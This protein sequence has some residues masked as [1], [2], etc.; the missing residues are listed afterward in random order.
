MNAFTAGEYG[1]GFETLGSH[2]VAQAKSRF[3]QC[4]P[5]NAFA[6][7]EVGHQPVCAFDVI[8]PSE[9][10]SSPFWALQSRRQRCVGVATVTVGAAY[11][12]I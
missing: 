8:N 2:E 9:L 11:R 4:I 1:P 5:L 7:I 10:G 6:G 12:G 3:H